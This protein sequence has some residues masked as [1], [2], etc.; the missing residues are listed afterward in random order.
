MPVAAASR[1]TAL[2]RSAVGH[3]RHF[4]GVVATST[5]L[6]ISEVEAIRKIGAMGHKRKSRY[7]EMIS[8]LPPQ[9]R[10]RSGTSPTSAKGPFPDSCTA[11][12]AR[13]KNLISNIPLMALDV[14][15]A[16]PST[17]SIPDADGMPHDGGSRS[18]APAGRRR[19]FSSMEPKR[20]NYLYAASIPLKEK[21]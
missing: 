18:A 3:Y 17:A 2:D 20:S 6:P 11:A 9:S 8:A 5:I 16:E 7:F 21:Q 10:R 15:V 12:K 4:G 13:R 19:S 14:S 1:C